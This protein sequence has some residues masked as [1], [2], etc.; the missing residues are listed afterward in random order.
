[1][2]AAFQNLS[3]ASNSRRQTRYS[4]A[5]VELA[6]IVASG[7]QLTRTCYGH[8]FVYASLSVL[9]ILLDAAYWIA[10]GPHGP[11]ALSPEG[12]TAYVVK[13][14]AAGLAVSFVLFVIIRMFARPAP[15]TMN[16]QYQ[17]M[18]NEYLRVWRI[19]SSPEH[20]ST[21]HIVPNSAH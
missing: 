12:Q 7:F 21:S 16:A 11:R 8:C 15:K 2:R 3:W 14:V 9:T 10:F 20:A 5:H 19:L 1:M 17:E 18:T 13:S 4:L 6:P